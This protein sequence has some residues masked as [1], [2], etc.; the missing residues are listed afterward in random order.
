MVIS[1]VVY[2]FLVNYKEVVENPQK[3][4]HAT[5]GKFLLPFLGVGPLSESLSLGPETWGVP[6]LRV[7]SR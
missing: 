2:S 5:V 4:G 7:G 1:I 3:L 6:S